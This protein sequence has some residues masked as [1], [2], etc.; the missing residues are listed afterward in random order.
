M[1]GRTGK[2]GLGLAL[3]LV[4]ATIL[5][6]ADHARASHP[7]PNPDW[8]YLY[9]HWDLY[10]EPRSGHLTWKAWTVTAGPVPYRDALI[11]MDAVKNKWEAPLNYALVAGGH[12]AFNFYGKA[13][14]QSAE[15]SYARM[16]TS[17]QVLWF[18]GDPTYLGCFV[19][20][21]SSYDSGRARREVTKASIIYG[22]AIWGDSDS[23]FLH[24][25]AHEWGHGFGLAHHPPC[26]TVMSP[27]GCTNLPVPADIAT[28]LGTVYGY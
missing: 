9:T 15:V 2:L 18:C 16:D 6:H 3:A 4:G 1:T 10:P 27:H 25:A 13:Y 21:A 12:R 20:D 14:N 28:A 11:L 22:P 5:N 7:W 24:S 17:Q 26:E 23:K 19:V 8:G